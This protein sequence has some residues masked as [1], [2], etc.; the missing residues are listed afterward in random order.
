MRIIKNFFWNSSYQMIIILLPLITAP[1]ITR[2]LGPKG[3]GIYSFTG[4]VVQYFVLFAL[5]GNYIYGNRE[6]A[7]YQ[8]DKKQR[9]QV[10]WGINFVTWGVAFIVFII[11]ILFITYTEQ[12]KMIY[13]IQSILI[14]ASLF[15]ISWYFQGRENFKIIVIR[16]LLVKLTTVIL[17]FLFVNTKSDLL[18]YISLMSLG[19]LFG[20][21][22]LWGYLKNEIYPPIF[23]NIQLKKHFKSS[24][25]LF[26][27]A[28]ISQFYL[29]ANRI[30]IG[31][32]DSVTNAGFFAQSDTIVRMTL[33]VITSLS[34]VMLPNITNLLSTGNIEAVKKNIEIS[35]KVST[36]IAV[37][38]SFGLAAI[39]LNFAPFFFGSNFSKVGV[40]LIIES[41][42]VLFLTWSTVIGFQYLLPMNKMKEYIFSSLVGAIS[43]VIINTLLIPTMG[44]LGATI[45]SV[46][47]EFLVFLT[48]FLLVIKTFSF[49]LL[50]KGSWKYFLS[51]FLMFDIVLFINIK[52]G[53][54]FLQ[55]FLQIFIGCI[56]YLFFNII[57]KTDLWII[58]KK[59]YLKY[60]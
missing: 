42:I 18:L 55:L 5:L 2:V 29:I 19:T 46:V 8:N 3:V 48:Q 21:L 52:F 35:F 16:N 31:S 26:F 10:F 24:L 34:I 53:M 7:F 50:F 41:P 37:P 38:L 47:A 57:L 49:K 6:I 30:M 20:N 54:S 28:L 9:S 11:Y 22:S 23:K 15:D 4:S 13:I 45:G 58:V 14:F 33:T 51:G 1:Y 43:C 25:L 27:P 17:I 12:Y 59:L 60:L 36:S 40:I 39:A 56:T 32:L 44:V